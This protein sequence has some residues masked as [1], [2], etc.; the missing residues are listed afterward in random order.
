MNAIQDQP[1]GRFTFRLM[2]SVS[3]LREFLPWLGPPEERRATNRIVNLSAESDHDQPA[4]SPH[5]NAAKEATA[6]R[7]RLMYQPLRSFE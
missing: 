5:S 6:G 2:N 3:V 7:M 4:S 1:G